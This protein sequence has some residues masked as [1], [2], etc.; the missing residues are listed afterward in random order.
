MD[1]L[2]IFE[3]LPDPRNEHL[4]TYELKSLVFIAISAVVSG[5]ENYT[6]IALFA[7]YKRDWITKYVSL[8]EEKTPSHDI[9]GDFFSALDPDKFRDCFVQWVSL[10]SNITSGELVAI[11]GKRVRAS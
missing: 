5:Y 11:D 1:S 8:P 4:I 9:F 7:E 3:N 2:K 10:V 6:E